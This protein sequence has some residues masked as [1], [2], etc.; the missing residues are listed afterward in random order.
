M[1]KTIQILAL[2]QG[3]FLLFILF[4]NQ[5][6]Y[7]QITFRLFIGSIISILLFIIGDDENNLFTENIDLFLFDVSLFIT[8]LFLFFKYFKSE[9]ESFNKVDWLFFLPNIVFLSLEIIELVSNKEHFFLEILELSIELIF[10]SYLFNIIYNLFKTKSKYW[11]LYTSI[12]IILLLSISYINDILDLLGFEAIIITNDRNFN[13]CLILIITFLFY[14]MIFYLISKPKDLLPTKKLKRYKASNLKP[15]L[16][17]EYKL[18]LIQAMEIDKLY[19]NSKLSI[20]TVSENINIPR[21]YIS[22][23]LN[24]HLHKSFIDFINEYRVDAFI[25]KIQNEQNDHFTLIAIANDVGFN[26]KSSFNATFKKIKGLT[27]T[28]FKKSLSEKV[29]ISPS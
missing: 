18:K 15:E 7:K 9:K 24:L 13:S 29:Q 25:K 2:V 23:V 4:K 28:E 6:K 27:P 3:M 22:E 26:S 11:L 5:K 1:L 21:Q 14:F 20:H 16:I 12:P 19:S 8:F 17:E 10:L